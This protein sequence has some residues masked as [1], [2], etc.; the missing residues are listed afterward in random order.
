MESI[1]TKLNINIKQMNISSNA[2]SEINSVP[3]SPIVTETQT[4]IR[5]YYTE[6]YSTFGLYT[7][8]Q[9]TA[10]AL[11]DTIIPSIQIPNYTQQIHL[12]PFKQISQI[13]QLLPIQTIP[14][15]CAAPVNIPIQGQT[16]R[17]LIHPYSTQSD[18]GSSNIPTHT[19]GC[20]W[21]ANKLG[22][23]I[24]S[25]CRSQPIN[26]HSAPFSSISQ[27]TDW[28][29]AC[30]RE[31]ATTFTLT[32]QQI[33]ERQAGLGSKVINIYNMFEYLNYQ[34][35]KRMF[36]VLLLLCDSIHP[37]YLAIEY[38]CLHYLKDGNQ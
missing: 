37:N 27:S 4:R 6:P 30:T 12:Q 8:Q 7:A 17:Q 10:P 21:N 24:K 15:I 34:L 38:I 32:Q 25:D 18:H 28:N 23:S 29:A 33:N 1:N 31:R 26:K 36:Y 20:D 19:F 5:S 16:G 9:H 22:N 35:I 14:Q 2:S 13:P 3:T 11:Y